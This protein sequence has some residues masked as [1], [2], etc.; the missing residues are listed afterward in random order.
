[1][2]LKEYDRVKFELAA[3]LRAA[4]LRIPNRQ[5]ASPEP[6]RNLYARLAEDR[7]N[8]VV[9][10]RFNRGKT[11]LMNAMMATECLPTGIV[12]LTS[13]ITTVSYGSSER[14]VIEYQRRGLPSQVGI[15]Q[16]K[17]Y[18]TQHGNP[19][20]TRGVSLARVQLPAEILRRGFHFIDTPGLGSSIIENTRTTE[21]FLPEA[22]ALMLVTSYDS[23]LSGEELRL[24]Q[25]VAPSARR[26]FLVVNKHDF[27][28][29]DERGQV[30]AHIHDQ[31]AHMLKTD[32]PQVFS[33][34]ARQALGAHKSLDD[35]QWSESGVPALEEQ[36]SRF[37]LE[38][39]Q[40]EFLF[41]MCERIAVLLHDVPDS[42]SEVDRLRSLQQGLAI[43][44]ETVASATASGIAAL[45]AP[46]RFTSCEICRKVDKGLYDFLCKFQGDLVRRQELRAALAIGGG[47]CDFHIWQYQSVASPRG[48][49]I[50]FPDV[51]A[52]LSD[53]LRHL[54][55]RPDGDVDHKT[56]GRL[57]PTS[58]DCPVCRVHREIERAAVAELVKRIGDQQG[59]GFSPVCLHHFSLLA[60]AIGDRETV[61]RLLVAEASALDRVS[62]D[63]RR[64]VMR[65]DGIR[66]ALIT[67]EEE[68]ADVRGLV[69]LAG[70]P[71]V[72]GRRRPL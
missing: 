37:L 46:K 12:P 52:N 36:L 4:E 34:S 33:V 59:E 26:I 54:A 53:R 57:R 22:D 7:F 2:D 5:G 28:S 23:P 44:P 63:M 49:C 3:I 60:E 66:R 48:T 38:D 61:R 25:G 65:I 56:F 30:L 31:M 67:R 68:G 19:G 13:V 18:V 11:S 1:M 72:S 40:S 45:A 35:G 47:L 27:V 20:N 9:V 69:L 62:E 24:L 50:G 70:H 43:R 10:G 58:E 21:A 71:N 32:L 17:D 55:E 41:Q 51:L 29:V 15:D 6:F 14:V 39:K 16:L 64:Y 8:L 42:A